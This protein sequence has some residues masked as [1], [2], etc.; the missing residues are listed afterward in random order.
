MQSFI[1]CVCYCGGGLPW[2]RGVIWPL[3]WWQRPAVLTNIAWTLL[4]LQLPGVLWDV[5]W[6]LLVPQRA[7]DATQ[8]EGD[9]LD[10]QTS[11]DEETGEEGRWAYCR[12]WLATWLETR[13]GCW[14]ETW[15][16][17]TQNLRC[18]LT[19]NSRW[20][21][22]WNLRCVLTQNLH[23]FTQNLKCVALLVI[24]MLKNK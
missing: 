6:P 20:L 13:G 19:W 16:V 18:V 1:T 7:V 11:R 12:L 23:K 14:L 24:I 9:V 10:D 15:G 8:D 4:W 2:L 17:L 21:L 3:L 22:T 5:T